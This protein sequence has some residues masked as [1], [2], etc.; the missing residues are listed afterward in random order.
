[1]SRLDWEEIHHL[2]ETQKFFVLHAPRQ[3]GKTTT[4][5]A[6]ADVLNQSGDYTAL[7]INVESA[8]SARGMCQKA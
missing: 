6:M 1:M 3:T 5:L 2:I 7:Y 4:L 8:Q